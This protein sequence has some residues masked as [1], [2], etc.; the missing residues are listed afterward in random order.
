MSSLEPIRFDTT[1]IIPAIQQHFV[2]CS[3]QRGMERE[4]QIDLLEEQR[5][6]NA[7]SCAIRTF[8]TLTFLPPWSPP[9]QTEKNSATAERCSLV[10]CLARSSQTWGN[11]SKPGKHTGTRPKQ[12]TLHT[13]Q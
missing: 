12:R 7:R 4:R 13:Q 8:P 6:S 2:V 10:N 3:L 5:L 11:A 1:H 9:L